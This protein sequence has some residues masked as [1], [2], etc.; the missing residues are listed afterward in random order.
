MAGYSP[1]C[2]SSASASSAFEQLIAGPRVITGDIISRGRGRRD[3]QR[4]VQ[5]RRMREGMNLFQLADA[6]LRV[7]LRGGQFRMSKHR[8]DESNVRA[9]L[10]HQRCHRVA[11]QVAGAGLA[12]LAP[13]TY[14]RT[15]C[16]NRFGENMSP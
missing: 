9:V 4:L 2:S 7:N 13:S 3:V 12:E 1:A 15:I 6:H 10:Q 14:S 8:L 16:V 5:P 11:E